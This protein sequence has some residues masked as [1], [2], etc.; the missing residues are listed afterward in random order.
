MSPVPAPDAAAPAPMDRAVSAALEGVR[1]ANPLVGAVVIGPDGTL[2]AM[3]HHR[4]AGTAHAEVDALEAFARARRTDPAVDAVDPRTCT[5]HVTL[6]PCDH[7]GRTDPCSQAILAAG[8]GHCV[9]AVADATGP[10]DGG[11]ARLRRHG[12]AVEGPTGHPDAVALTSRWRAVQDAGRP[13]VTARLAQSLDGQAAAADGTSQWITSA[14]ARAHSH[15]LRARVDAI[16]VGTGTVLADDPSLTARTPKSGLAGTQPVPVVLGRRAIPADAAVHRHPA[17]PV[18]H[19]TEQDPGRVLER[20]AEHPGPWPH[21][22]TRCAH[23]MLEGGPTLIGAWLRAG[24]VDEL[25]VYTAPVLLG[26]GLPAVQD[27]RIATLADA[28]RWHP[29]P[30]QQGP[31][32][33]LGPDVWTHLSPVPAPGWT[34][35]KAG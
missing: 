26:A 33:T 10:E 1:G 13:W 11:A 3:G 2:L 28:L 8:I 15:K 23:V 7:T 16:L 6:E 31:V 20:I 12:V 5:L 29:D 25:H 14:A 27:L 9:Y 18:L 19:L 30:A 32:R 21:G 24:L 22:G 17:G 34:T 35:G 4:G